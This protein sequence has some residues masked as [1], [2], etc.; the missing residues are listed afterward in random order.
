MFDRPADDPVG[1]VMSFD[2]FAV[3]RLIDDHSEVWYRHMD[4]LG[5]EAHS[6]N[7]TTQ[8][9]PLLLRPRTRHRHHDR[10]CGR[11]HRAP[12]P[13]VPRPPLSLA[14]RPRPGAAP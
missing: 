4:A 9:R 3:Q 10:W 7:H 12:R 6:W 13:E 2:N 8:H 1:L 14:R 5:F 11:V